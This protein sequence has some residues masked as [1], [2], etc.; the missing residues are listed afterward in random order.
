MFECWNRNAHFPRRQLRPNYR[1]DGSRYDLASNARSRTLVLNAVSGG[2]AV[3][4]A[5]ILF[6]RR[7][8]SNARSRR[9]V[10]N[11]VSGGAAIT[12][13]VILFVRGPASNA[14]SRALVVNPVPGGAAV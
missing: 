13:A 1:R 14:R 9:L 10:L 2:A 5:V 3:T 12:S 6:V 7:P 11:A 4:F 8:A